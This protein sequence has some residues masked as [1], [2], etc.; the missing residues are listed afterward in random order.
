MKVKGKALAPLL[1]LGLLLAAMGG[2]KAKA[3][4]KP[5]SDVP[6]PFSD[7]PDLPDVPVL[8]EEPDAPEP[9]APAP[10]PPQPEPEPQPE[11]PE[12]PWYDQPGAMKVP[13][14]G[15]VQLLNAAAG[16]KHKQSILEVPASASYAK[17][18]KAYERILFDANPAADPR[19][20]ELP[21][22]RVAIL[23]ASYE[24][25]KAAATA[26]EPE[27]PAPT[28]APGPGPTP[29]PE[30]DEPDEP[31]EPPA[32]PPPEPAPEP[33]T[34]PQPK[35]SKRSTKASQPGMVRA[36]V[37]VV[38]AL[39]RRLGSKPPAGKPKALT[40]NAWGPATAAAWRAQSSA[41]SLDGTI[42]RAGPAAAWVMPA[43]LEAL[44]RALQEDPTPP[45][46]APAPGPAPA[47]APEP[48]APP[49]DPEPD[50]TPP[51]PAPAPGPAPAP[52]PEPEEPE[53]P[54]DEPID[55]P[56]APAPTPQ[57]PAGYDPAK[58]RKLAKQV[59]SN[60]DRTE[61]S[62]SRQLVKDFQKFAGIDID[63]HY[64][65]ETRGA[66]IHY[67]VPRPPRALFKPTETVPYRWA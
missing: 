55:E 63:G 62:Y 3:R 5:S 31:D 16:A 33:K 39:V 37:Q 1:G 12:G 53:P 49:P 56:P 47:P 11:E 22:R 4:T 46:P 59:A 50:P 51:A 60:V 30:P 7:L 66:L 64:G 2:K 14:L 18:A 65:G 38:Q 36:S 67:G 54:I 32:P 28:P 17:V 48:P 44:K 41:R 27:P 61:Y 25:L 57:Y 40:D 24:T 8:P 58:A 26:A 45:A 43:T 13:Q 34:K 20:A 21:D 42:D 35:P 9:P 19:I 15:L 6:D 52:A 23:Q 29:A 10:E